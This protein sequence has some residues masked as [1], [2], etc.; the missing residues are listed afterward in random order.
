MTPLEKDRQVQT[1]TDEHLALVTRE[2]LRGTLTWE[3]LQQLN[4]Q[5]IARLREITNSPSESP[6]P[7]SSPTDSASTSSH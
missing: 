6:D 7:E 3:R 5:T 1:V 4:R 2:V